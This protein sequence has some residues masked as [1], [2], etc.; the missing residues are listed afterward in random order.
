MINKTDPVPTPNEAETPLPVDP[1][2]DKKEDVAAAPPVDIP[3]KIY[4]A[5]SAAGLDWKEDDHPRDHGK[6]AEKDGSADAKDNTS[7]T[8]G[9]EPNTHDSKNSKE[10][11]EAGNKI[12][13]QIL[14]V[15]DSKGTVED[16]HILNET[17]DAQRILVAGQHHIERLIKAR[18]DGN[19]KTWKWKPPIVA[20]SDR[21]REILDSN[22]D[23][24]NYARK[25]K[26]AIATMAPSDFLKLASSYE[27]DK[28]P[29]SENMLVKNMVAGEPINTPYLDIKKDEKTGKFQVVSHEGR[30]R[31]HAAIRAG[32]REMPVYFY[33]QSDR[34]SDDD[35]DKLSSE[36]PTWFLNSER[37]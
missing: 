2:I 13:T 16:A 26:V 10:V 34:L 28:N 37:N 8:H 18:H 3:T 21:D 31:S 9:L 32:I 22:N 36:N 23:W 17:N 4:K 33:S 27:H 6:F 30:H 24:L 12:I 29:N 20:K 15:N 11:R 25:G 1:V 7:S 35:L 14:A 19:P 5:A